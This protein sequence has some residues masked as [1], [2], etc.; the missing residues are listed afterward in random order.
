MIT[1]RVAFVGEK[2]EI[3]SKAQE[4]FSEKNAEDKNFEIELVDISGLDELEIQSKPSIVLFMM[5][6]K[7]LEQI[8]R[9]L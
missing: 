2:S 4:F 6:K 8:K 5:L 3:Y 7:L 1:Y 9:K